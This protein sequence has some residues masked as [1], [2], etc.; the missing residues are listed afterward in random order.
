MGSRIAT[1]GLFSVVAVVYIIEALR[2]PIGP[3]KNPG[4]GFFP[5]AIGLLLIVSLTGE[6]IFERH[7]SRAPE[8]TEES[9]PLHRRNYARLAGAAIVCIAYIELLPYFGLAAISAI[10]AY[11]LMLI[12]KARH[13]LIA[14]IVSIVIGLGGQYL[15]VDILSVPMPSTPLPFIS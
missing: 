4:S 10:S 15:F 1:I 2:L 3:I 5:L 9:E 12:G 8:A 13:R 6:A 14:L 7:A 11:A